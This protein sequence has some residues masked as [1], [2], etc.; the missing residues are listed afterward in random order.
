MTNDSNVCDFTLIRAARA[1][2]EAISLTPA[3]PAVPETPEEAALLAA[4]IAGSFAALPEQERHILR[5][6][7]LMVLADLMELNDQ[8]ERRRLEIEDKLARSRTMH[9]AAQAYGRW[10]PRTPANR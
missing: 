10:R 8:L 3:I 6:K 5:L 1:R 9:G 4:K 2:A 7:A